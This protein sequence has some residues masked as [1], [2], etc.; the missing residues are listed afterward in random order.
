MLSNEEAQELMKKFI[1]LRA[2]AKETQLD[3]DIQ[4]FR[5]YETLCIEKFQYLITMKT[6]KYKA[7][8]NY[9]DLNQ[10]G[11]EALL[12]AMK[13]Y[14]P[15]RGSFFWW[16][17]KYIGTRISRCANLHTTIRYPLRVAKLT[18]PHKESVMPLLIEERHCPDKEV[19]AS[20]TNQAIQNSFSFL[21][22]EQKEIIGLAYGLGGDKPMSVNKICRQFNISRLNCIKLINRALETMR[23]NIKT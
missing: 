18:V 4:S 16:A 5:K 8:A 9:E 10:E 14:D 11:F 22:T 19:E 2:K 20:Q 21:T 7:F 1:A 12:K 23:D 6:G 3:Q 15:A 13:N 17:H